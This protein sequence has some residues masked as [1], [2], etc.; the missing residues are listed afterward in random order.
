VSEPVSPLTKQQTTEAE[1]K[2]AK[3]SY[4]V[5]LALDLDESIPPIFGAP[6]GTTISGD[7]AIAAVND[8]GFKGFYGRTMCRFLNLFQKNHGAKAVAG[9]LERS[10]EV[11]KYE[12]DSGVINQ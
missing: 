11:E 9:D 5:R 4:P 3:H 12:E 2:S 1:A 6:L 7:A 8:K 10:E